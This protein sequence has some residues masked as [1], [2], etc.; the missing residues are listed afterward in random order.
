M[1][2]DTKEHIR[3][4]VH[5]SNTYTTFKFNLGFDN[6]GFQGISEVVLSQNS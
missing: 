6:P 3:M 4:Y 5:C 2:K 1:N